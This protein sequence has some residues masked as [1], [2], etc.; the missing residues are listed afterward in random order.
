MCGMTVIPTDLNFSTLN[1][2]LALYTM[3]FLNVRYWLSMYSNDEKHE[4][5]ISNLPELGYISGKQASTLVVMAPMSRGSGRYKG[6]RKIQ[7]GRH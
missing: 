4:T 5:T 7:G 3:L 2:I 6:L 1:L